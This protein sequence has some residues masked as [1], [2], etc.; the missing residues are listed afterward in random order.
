MTKAILGRDAI[1]A[2]DDR[3]VEEVE[4]FG[5]RVRV[6]AMDAH[7]WGRLAALSDG[8]D[9]VTTQAI[10]CA[11]FLVDEKGEPLFDM[12][13]QA[14]LDLLISKRLKTLTAISEAGMRLSRATAGDVEQLRENF[15]ETPGGDSPTG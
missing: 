14:D 10:M 4:A 5:G 12:E 8:K 2:A 15:P 13:N 7:T 9:T 1:L 6:R 3:P 11:A